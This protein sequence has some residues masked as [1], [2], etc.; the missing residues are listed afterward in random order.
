MKEN[1]LKVKEKG[2]TLIALVITIIVLLI[3]AGVTIATLTGDNGILSQ[4]NKAGTETEAAKEEE[5]RKLTTLEATTNLENT[6]YTDKN[7]ETVIVPAGF[8][9]SQVE[10]ENTIQD[11]LVIIDKNENEFVWVSITNDFNMLYD[12]GNNYTE[13]KELNSNYP[14]SG[15]I[16]DS[17]KTLDYLYGE[18]YYNYETDFAYLK[19]YT[20]MVTKIN[21][22]RGFYVGRYE[23][24]IEDKNTIGSKYNT[25]VLTAGTELNNEKNSKYLWWGLYEKQRN[26]NIQGNGQYIQTSMIWGQQWDAIIGNFEKRNKNYS[27]WGL[28]KQGTVIKSGQSIN[29]NNEKDKILNIYDLR[30]NGWDMT[31]E[32]YFNFCHAIRGGHYGKS[33]SAD[34][35][36]FGDPHNAN[37]GY[38][39]RMTFYIK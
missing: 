37:K 17:Q 8:A 20:E 14:D 2:I 6:I 22:Y 11:G 23:T 34:Y 9:V 39:T 16:M 30:T 35:R 25:T 32:T 24:T 26:N 18:E 15:A 31:A 3:L 7:N 27:E 36:H 1:K 28:S 29:D 12:N 10:G 33:S 21:E 13:P 19:H 4:A 38:T 5:L